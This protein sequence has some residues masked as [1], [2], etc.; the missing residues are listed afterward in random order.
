MSTR[1]RYSRALLAEAARQS[2]SI[3]E[4]IAFLGTSPYERLGRYLKE[5][6]DHYGIDTSHFQPSGRLPRP[7]SGEL[8]EAVASS[9]SVA[10]VLRRLGRPDNSSQ[11]Q[12]LRRWT[13]EAG[14]DTS[15]FRG[16]AHQRG[17]PG[18]TPAK[19]PEEVLVIRGDS[20][21]TQG[22]T[23]RRALSALGVPD[24]CAE[25]GTGPVWRGQPM[26]LEVDHINGEPGDNRAENLRLLCPNCHAVTSTWCRGGDRLYGS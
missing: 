19:R 18:T 5:R 13:S 6:F 21:R 2:G 22:V 20:R 23:L 8:R 14:L 15:H 9:V 26:T 7:T 10:A 25:C 24:V 4:V 3:D 1:T 16:Q 12:W 17:G 11:R